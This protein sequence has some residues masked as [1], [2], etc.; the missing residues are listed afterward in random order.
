MWGNVHTPVGRD[1]E[2]GRSRVIC[3]EGDSAFGFSGMEI[4]TIVR[5]KLPVIVVVVNNNGIYG[6]M[7]EEVFADVVGDGTEASRATSLTSPP[8]ALQPSVRYSNRK[9]FGFL[10]SASFF[11]YE[12]ILNMFGLEG[13]LCKTV[14]EI[15]AAMRRALDDK[16]LR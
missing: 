8:T 7:D 16:E 15:E 11:R 1:L 3:V 5:Y 4:E 6:G 10:F 9:F 13:S 12:K 2:G 14:P